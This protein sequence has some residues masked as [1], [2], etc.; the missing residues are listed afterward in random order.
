LC[1]V[2]KVAYGLSI[3]TKIAGFHS[4]T[5]NG[6]MAVIAYYCTE[7]VSFEADYEL[8]FEAIHTV[9]DPDNLVFGSI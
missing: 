2:K 9:C 6:V 3:G 1:L 7:C 4:V 8:A 5:L